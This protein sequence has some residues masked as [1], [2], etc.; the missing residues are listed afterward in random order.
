MK[1]YLGKRGYIIYK[2]EFDFNKLQEIKNE[3]TVQPYVPEDY[4]NNQVEKFKVYG[5]NKNKMYLPKFYGIEKL[6]PPD[7]IKIPRGLDANLDFIGTFTKQI[8]P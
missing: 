3:L 2:K 1:T 4:K 5:E 7:E 8:E 6:G